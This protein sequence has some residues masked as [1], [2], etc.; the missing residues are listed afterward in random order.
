MLKYIR[1]SEQRFDRSKAGEVVFANIIGHTDNNAA[2]Q[3]I[4]SE[5]QQAARRQTIK[6]IP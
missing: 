2:E 6:F 3:I 1:A 5:G 4:K